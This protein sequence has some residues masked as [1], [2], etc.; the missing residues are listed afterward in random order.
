MPSTAG[1]YEPK[2]I[3]VDSLW[4]G[5]PITVREPH[6]GLAGG[7][8]ARGYVFGVHGT[9]VGLL[10]DGAGGRRRQ[11][12]LTRQD[13][14]AMLR[15]KAAKLHHQAL[16]FDLLTDSY[17]RNPYPTLANMRVHCPV[18]R[19][20]QL[21]AWIVTRHSDVLSCLSD[22]RLSADRVSPR[23]SQLPRSLRERSRPL[24]DVLSNWPL[25]LDP[26]A[27]TRYRSLIARTMTRSA[28]E[29]Y[30]PTVRH[31][32]RQLVDAGIAQGGM[33]AIADLAY[34]LPLAV[35]TELIGLPPDGRDL[36]KACAVDIVNFFGCDPS[37]YVE[38]IAAAEVSVGE[39]SAFLRQVIRA[40]RR[41]PTADLISAL[42]AAVERGEVLDDEE[43]VALCLMMAF[44]G[45]ETTMN[46]IGNGLLALMTHPDQMRRL[47]S[48]RS[49][50]PRALDEMLRFEPP[51]QRL[52]RM[53]TAG[54]ELRG[55]QIRRGDL[56]F[57][58][59]SAAN[60]DP[61]RYVDPDQFDIMRD[62]RH[63]LSFGHSIHTCPGSTLAKL[64]ARTVFDDL[65]G[66]VAEIRLVDD[67]PDWQRNLSI[68]SLRRLHVT[69][70]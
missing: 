19:S 45:Y 10:L 17:A 40:K 50:L 8:D 24:V 16:M 58:M 68:R 60:R 56:V 14:P 28:V 53:A 30:V 29:R 3:A 63:A 38:R 21:Q 62:A 36:L 65:L 37:H 41:R 52:S 61:A 22:P 47:R 46:L 11:W 6:T 34:P 42:V 26:P 12:A 31:L 43:I 66:R 15:E 32:S 69:F 67:T 55:Q 51:V 23:V 44:A 9:R 4:T 48:D 64:E 2:E 54:I 25:M 13:P 35:V 57:L 27:H 7:F 59:A 49:L 18:Y 70:S 1:L 39:A 5:G 20:E 33:D